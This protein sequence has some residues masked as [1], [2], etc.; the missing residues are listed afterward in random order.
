M[1]GGK[2]MAIAPA[3]T[4]GTCCPLHV[5]THGDPNAPCILLVQGLGMAIT[6]WPADLI[7]RLAELFHV[8]CIDNRDAGKSFRCG[9]DSD[10]T[11]IDMLE[12]ATDVAPPYTLFDMRDDILR[13][14]DRLKI[15]RFALVGFSMG[16]MIAQLIAAKASNRITGLV[17]ICSSGGEAK[18]PTVNGAW[19]RFI[20][21]VKPFDS[22]AELSEWLAD[23]MIWWAA[24]NSPCRSDARRAAQRTMS[25][26]FTQGGYARQL[27]ALSHSGDR[28]P[29]LALI[30][31]PT[32]I[33]GGALDRCISPASSWRAHELIENS[34]LHIFAGMGHAINRQ[35]IDD[36]SSWLRCLG[37][38]Q[39]DLCP[40]SQPGRA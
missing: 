17:Q 15:S 24:P 18:L 5:E 39:P 20:R 31:A 7:N 37:A 1:S 8:V 38:E 35:V 26:G 4:T 36:T 34:E 10:A 22:K 2:Q 25:G 9:P 11:A 12:N 32:L 28:Q 19:A 21:T 13:C 3:K 29:I 23:D 16:G 14:L 6:D 40:N 27:L 33:I 30:S